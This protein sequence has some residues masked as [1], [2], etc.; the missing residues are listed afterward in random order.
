MRRT[1]AAYHY[2]VRQLRRDENAIIRERMAE[3][4]ISDPGRSFWAE[5]KR[6]RSCG[7]GIYLFI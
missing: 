7:R 2:A 1:R 5:I 4:L 6:I 3:A